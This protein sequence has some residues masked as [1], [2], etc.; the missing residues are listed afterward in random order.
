MMTESE[1]EAHGALVDHYERGGNFTILRAILDRVPVAILCNEHK[2][3]TA[4]PLAM[5]LKEDQLCRL[6]M[7]DGTP[8]C[9]P[10]PS[11]H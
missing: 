10:D 4:R 2:D 9:E 5:L 1:L 3:G 6:M 7:E 11:Q 8:M